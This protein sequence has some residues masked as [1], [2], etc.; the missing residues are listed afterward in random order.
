MKNKEDDY[1]VKMVDAKDKQ[2]NWQEILEAKE[3]VQETKE[4]MT[5]TREIMKEQD[6]HCQQVHTKDEIFSKTVQAINFVLPNKI[7][8]EEQKKYIPLSSLLLPTKQIMA[9]AQST[10]TI[11]G[12][13]LTRQNLLFSNVS[14]LDVEFSPTRESDAAIGL[15]SKIISIK[16]IWF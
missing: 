13:N 11:A 2:E 7:N 8:C 6:M 4:C 3:G 9:L 1:D 10:S 14:K 12:C 15:K 16:F 5:K